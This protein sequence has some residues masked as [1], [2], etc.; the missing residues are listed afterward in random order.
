MDNRETLTLTDMMDPARATALAATMGVDRSYSVGDPLPPFGQHV[1][2]W[3]PEPPHGLADNGHAAQDAGL[4]DL[5]LPRRMWAAGRLVFHC[6]LLAGVRAERRTRIETITQKDGRSGRLAFVRLRHDIRQRQT[7]A[8]TEW[9]DIVYRATDADTP[10]PP[11]APTDQT[12]TRVHHFDSVTL[13]RY[14]ALTFNGHRIHY[15]DPYAR[16]QGYGGLVVHAPLLAHLLMDFATDALGPLRSFD[17]R[18]TAPLLVHEAA[19]LCRRATDLWVRAPDGRLCLTAA[20][21]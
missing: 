17:Y 8:L 7:L 10:E 16:A 15:D 6:D 21:T 13:F 14:S 18:A 20:A 3:T 12:D 1:Y 19:T 9:Q 5:G 4:P 11:R 2:F